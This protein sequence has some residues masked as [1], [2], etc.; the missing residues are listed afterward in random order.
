[1]KPDE[2][3]DYL[4]E[5]SEVE[6]NPRLKEAAVYIRKQAEEINYWREKFNKA[7]ELWVK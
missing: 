3:A 1:M 4:Q 2:I 7:C 5:K 6:L